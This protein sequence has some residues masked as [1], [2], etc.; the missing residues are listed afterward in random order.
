MASSFTCLYFHIV[1]STKRRQPILVD[2]IAPRIWAYLGGI[3]RENDMIPLAIGGYHDH[4]HLV[5]RIKP[6]I[7]VSRM[8]QLLKGGSSHWIHQEFPGL[9]SFQW[10]D[11][12]SAFSISRSDLH[13]VVEYVRSQKEHHRK[14]SFKEEYLKFLEDHQIPYDPRY[15]WD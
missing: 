14:R 3:A 8:M 11:G 6:T 4:V 12:Y 5:I 7:S 2:E 1:F 10:Q 15:V 13:R 9:R